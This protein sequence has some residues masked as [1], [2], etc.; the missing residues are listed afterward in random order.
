MLFFR[1]EEHLNNWAQYDP[2]TAAGVSQLDGLAKMFSSNMFK[3][4]LE[5]DY[6]SNMKTYLGE[7]IGEMGSNDKVGKFMKS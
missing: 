7:M 2:A 6:I 4:R 3:R 1:S 5:Q